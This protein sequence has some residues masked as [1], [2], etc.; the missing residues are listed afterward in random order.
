M[1]RTA[2]LGIKIIIIY[3]IFVYII[4]INNNI[5]HN[6]YYCMKIMYNLFA[7]FS[8]QCIIIY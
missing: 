6:N 7:S 3:V 4:I 1:I 8:I 5:I 2:A